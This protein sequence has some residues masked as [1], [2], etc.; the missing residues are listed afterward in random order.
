MSQ[1][2]WLGNEKD[3]GFEIRVRTGWKDDET[4]LLLNEVKKSGGKKTSVKSRFF[5]GCR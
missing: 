3:N 2:R 5:Q 4:E 1:N